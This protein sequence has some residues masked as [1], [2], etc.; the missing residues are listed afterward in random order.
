MLNIR[1]WGELTPLMRVA[2]VMGFM[3]LGLMGTANGA[4]FNVDSDLDIFGDC[5]TPLMC[6]LRQAILEANTSVGIED[7]INLPA[8]IYLLDLGFLEITDD[9]MIKGTS[10]GST[11]I[12][13]QGLDRVLRVI[14]GVVL[15]E[16]LTITGG[17]ATSRR[18]RWDPE[19]RHPDRHEQY[20]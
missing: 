9:L 2:L 8:G 19:H 14:S 17:S 4:T 13:G 7:T 16:N 12:D 3:A 6:T 18:R 5:S 20:D 10:S 11:V 15:L 1:M